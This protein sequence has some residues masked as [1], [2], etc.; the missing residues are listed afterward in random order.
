MPIDTSVKNVV[1]T[2][3]DHYFNFHIKNIL[4]NNYFNEVKSLNTSSVKD[5]FTYNEFNYKKA[6]KITSTHIESRQYLRVSLLGSLLKIYE[7]NTAYKTQLQ[8]IFEMQ[9]I[10]ADDNE[11]IN[12]TG[13]TE[14]VV[15]LDKIN[16]SSLAYN[17][18]GLKGVV[19]EIARFF[20]VNFKYRNF[21]N[22][23]IF[24]DNECVEV[25]ENDKTIG[26][27]GCIK[28]NKL[29]YAINTKKIY[30]FSL[31]LNNLINN[32]KLKDFKIKHVSNNM[33]IYKD[34]SFFVEN[35]ET[36]LKEVINK[37]S[38]KKFVDSCEFVDKFITDGKTSYTIKIKFNNENAKISTDEIDEYLQKIID[39]LIEGNDIV[40][41]NKK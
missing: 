4:T 25:L 26:F 23:N 8:P 37:I 3:D 7:K 13:I 22:S 31:N 28:I 36:N 24:Y 34:I 15:Q 12:V 39:I 21:Q 33:P 10:Y 30:C 27:I 1:D 5:L 19:N 29:P 40:V 6:T 17:V 38:L 14:Q 20:N 32:Y 11:T 35:K 18:V 16:K 2:I 9:K 41:R